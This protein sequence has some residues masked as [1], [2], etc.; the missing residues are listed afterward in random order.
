MGLSVPDLTT[1]LAVLC[2]VLTVARGVPQAARARRAHA[3]GVSRGTWLLIIV[4]AELWLAYGFVFRVPAQI[5]ANL[6]NIALAGLIVYL[7][8]RAERVL[9]QSV[10]AA[11]ALTAGATAVT[12]AS[13]ATHAGWVLS[14]PAVMGSISL[15]LPQTAKVLRE[16]DLAGVS[17]TTWLL[18]LL[19]ALGWG[20]YGLL[21]HQPPIWIPCAVTVPSSLVIVV[22]VLR[23]PSLSCSE[24]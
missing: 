24:P 13:L 21:I 12:M 9:W 19:A 18:A 14:V 7:V 4:V 3:D 20:A 17:L 1:T 8:A 11:A 23:A 6:P 16:V 15:Y 2:P 5:A 10:A 22:R